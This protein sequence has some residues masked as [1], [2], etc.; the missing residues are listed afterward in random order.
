MRV[1]AGFR[2]ISKEMYEEFCSL[3]PEIELDFAKW[4]E[5]VYTWNYLYRD[6]IL[7]TGEMIKYPHGIGEFSISKKQTT[8]EVEVNGKKH[9]VLPIDW[10]KS[11][12]AGKKIY[13]FN[14]HTDGWRCKWWWNKKTARFKL[15]EL[16][17]FKPYRTSSRKLSEYLK[18]PN[19]KFL[20]LYKNYQR[21]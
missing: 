21:R 5:I 3:H 10:K 15:S 14:S 12:A 17:N 6:Y 8:R 1:K 19:S 16:Y 13:I 11:K 4:K 18:K 2:Q 20:Q 9:I 7:E